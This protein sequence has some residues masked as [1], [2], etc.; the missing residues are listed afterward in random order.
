VIP[1]ELDLAGLHSYREHQTIAFDKAVEDG[2]FG[3]FGPTGSGK[4]TLLDAMT[5]ALYGTVDRLGGRD[6]TPMMH[7]DA[8]ELTVTYTFDLGG[9][10][11]Q[12]HRRFV[13][14][15]DGAATQRDAELRDLDAERTLASQAREMTDTVE[16]ILGMTFDQFTRAVF[17]PQGKFARFLEDTKSQRLELLEEIFGL[18]KYGEELRKRARDR[19]DEIRQ[20]HDRI[21]GELESEEM[22]NVSAERVA[23]LENEHES[24]VERVDQLAEREEALAEKAEAA[25]N[26]ESTLEDLDEAQDAL[27]ELEERADAIDAKRE[28]AERARA[29]Q[30]PHA[31]LEDRDAA[32]TTLAEVSEDLEA[33]EERIDEHENK[34]EEAETEREQAR[35]RLDERE[36][37]LDEARARIEALAGDAARLDDLRSD[38]DEARQELAELEDERVETPPDDLAASHTAGALLAAIQRAQR[39]RDQVDRHEQALNEARQRRGEARLAMIEQ[40]S[41]LDEAEERIDELEDELEAAKSRI[42]E[43]RVAETAS[44][45]V[46]ELEDGEPCPVCGSPEHPAPTDPP[47]TPIHELEARRDEVAEALTQARDE[48][49]RLDQSLEDHADRHEEARENTR[50]ARQKLDEARAGLADTREGLPDALAELTL[51]EARSRVRAWRRAARAADARETID[52]AQTRL[53][54]ARE[55]FELVRSTLELDAEEPTEA[56][57]DVARDRLDAEQARVDERRERLDEA[58]EGAEDALAEV[59]EEHTKLAGREEELTERVDQLTERFETQLAESPFDAADEVKAAHEPPERVDK[60]EAKVES[61]DEQLADARKAVDRLEAEVEDAEVEPDEAEDVLDEHERVDEALGQARERRGQVRERLQTQR[62]RLETK[63]GLTERLEALDERLTR[64]EEL[65]TLLG[66]RGFVEYLARSRFDHVLDQASRRLAQVSGGQYH[67]EGTP[68]EI[69]VVDQMAGGEARDLRTLSGGETFMVSLSLAL[70]LSDAIQHERGGGYPPI[71]FFFLDEGFG[72]LDGDTLDQVMRM[73]HELVDQDVH[74][75][76][77][78]HVEDAK[79]YIPRQILVEKATEEQGSRVRVQT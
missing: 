69:H 25:R 60:I 16:S 38:R 48:R 20:T 7:V 73:L 30:T 41:R 13:R 63:I 70:A 42:E 39:T 67:L 53:E 19:R 43:A 75:G 76:L 54:E 4:S 68:S 21:T 40:A 29:A 28:R 12:A 8:D 62:D 74:V 35:E 78:T 44:T 77:I 65:T 51:E 24:V 2:L 34:L 57:V 31:T 58:V 66:S 72:S 15:S 14:G 64:A 32:E 79:R 6:K 49:A 22:Q 71:E 59:R 3:I 56:T 17:L 11:Y 61:F 27:A 33:I 52:E 46:T 1:R 55:R 18:D 5:L 45:L 26:L 36:A 37:E 23:K 10:R 50:T 9:T 47:E